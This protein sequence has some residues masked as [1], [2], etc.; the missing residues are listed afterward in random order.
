MKFTFSAPRVAAVSGA[1]ALALSLA[2]ASGASAAKL[3]TV[4][5]AYNPNPSNTTIVI[6]QQQGFF[7]KNGINAVLTAS[8]N[9]AAL[10]P[11]I[12]KQYDIVN[13]TPPSVLQAA[14][15]GEKL[16]VFASETT[17]TSKLTDT[18][19]IAAKSITSLKDL[20]GATIGVPGLSGT[21]YESAVIALNKVGIKKNQ[22]KFLSVPFA[23]DAGDLANGTIQATC[24]IVPFNGQLLGEGFTNLGDPEL[25][26]TGGH[27]GLD[28][29]WGASRSW[30]LSHESILSG[31]VKAQEQA[32]T[33]IKGHQSATISLLEKD[34][35]LPAQAAEH[36]PL[37]QYFSFPMVKSYLF[38]WV[39]PMKAVG[40]LPKSY[41]PNYAQLITKP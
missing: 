7:K 16:T 1:A 28:I 27:T 35:Q 15:A 39:S 40:D 36:Y 14:A 34:F 32:D 19:L 23:D 3:T 11:A 30:A 29:G 41:T 5:I 10:I 26:V 37:Y 17:E 9:T 24:T 2:L 4:R 25:N 12:G 6:A 20:K 33:W 31:F 38:D 18:Y 8:Q 22:V 13:A 21:L